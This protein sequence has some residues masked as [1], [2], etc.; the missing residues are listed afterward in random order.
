MTSVD[1]MSMSRTSNTA[2]IPEISNP[3]TVARALWVTLLLFVILHI[4]AIAGI[5]WTAAP[6]SA[7]GDPHD[8]RVLPWIVGL[9][10]GIGVIGL[11]RRGSSIRP[12]L[13]VF[14]VAAEGLFLGGI[15]TYFEGVLPGIVL[16]IVF[17]LL[18]VVA[19]FLPLAASKRFRRLRQGPR[20]L[21]LA[22]TGYLVFAVHNLTLMG[23][24][25]IPEQTA[26]GQ[27]SVSVLGVP[28]GLVLAV[29]VVP[30]I[31]YALARALERT[32]EVARDK[33]PSTRAW[34]SGLDIM[35]LIFWHPID[36]S[37]ALSR[38]RNH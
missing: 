14:A 7:T 10:V 5:L 16:Q 15:A 17:A 35:G 8:V 18:S 32:E 26:W 24:D 33:A 13:A 1:S 37:Q 31:A 20:V 38:S 12:S 21:L 36:T 2:P 6:A 11:L 27:G 34:R 22:V 3:V 9:G 29:L 4:A 30:S 23:M 25:F 28:V 19:A